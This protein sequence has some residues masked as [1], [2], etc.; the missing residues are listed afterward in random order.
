MI[1]IYNQIDLL[2]MIII[3]EMVLLYKI[4]SKWLLL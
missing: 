1:F 3:M 2:V 4:H